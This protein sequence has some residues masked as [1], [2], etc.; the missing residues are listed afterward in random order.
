MADLKIKEKRVLEKLLEMGGGYVCDFS[1]RTFQEFVADAVGL[2]LYQERYENRGSSKAN[3]LRAFWEVEDNHTVARLLSELVEYCEEGWGNLSHEAD[4]KLVSRARSIVER[5]AGTTVVEDLDALGPQGAEQAADA[6]ARQI[7]ESIQAGRPEEALDRLHT[8]L[9][10]WVRSLCDEHDIDYSRKTPL[11]GLFGSYVR[12]LREEGLV[13][14]RATLTILSSSIKVLDDLNDVR[15]NKSLAH[16]NE[17]LE[18][19][20]ATLIFRNIS[21]SMKFI[22]GVERRIQAKKV[23]K[24]VSWDDPEFS[25]EEIEAADEYIQ[26]EIDRRRG[27]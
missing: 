5:L 17:I 25:E 13:E 22:Q 14:T 26:R 1:N 10:S 19:S 6:L 2:D 12:F 9:V 20:E 18:R 21:S 23:T 15:N 11:H 8:W 27:K 24:A 16:D 3:R 4:P 7:Q